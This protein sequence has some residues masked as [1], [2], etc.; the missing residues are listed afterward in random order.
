MHC[1]HVSLDGSVHDYRRTDT[2]RPR[3][4]ARAFIWR[5]GI[6]CTNWTGRTTF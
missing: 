1:D 5:D 3:E 6:Y 2:L 4:T